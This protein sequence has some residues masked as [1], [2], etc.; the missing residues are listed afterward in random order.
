MKKYFFL[1]ICLLVAGAASAQRHYGP[2][3]VVRRPAPRHQSDDFYRVKVGITGGVNIANMVDTYNS[4]FATGTIAGFNA[5]LTLDVPLA[6]P[7]SFAPE[8]LYSQKGFSGETVDGNF[9]QRSHFIDVPLLLKIRANRNFN[10]VV[11]PQLAFPI[12]VTN[13]YDNGFSEISKEHYSTSGDKTL[14]GGVVGIGIDLNNFVELRG[15]YTMDFSKTSP[16]DNNYIPN[17]RNQ[18]WQIGLGIK[19]Q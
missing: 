16:N 12:S 5:G 6:Y 17:Y 8:V 13:T 19:F 11:G 18:V 10:F 2:R 7:L 3:R 14:V 4:D 9:T 15:R 1:A